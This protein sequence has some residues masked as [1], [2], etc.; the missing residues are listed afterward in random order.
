[1]RLAI[2]SFL[3]AMALPATAHAVAPD[4][5]DGAWRVDAD[6]LRVTAAGIAIPQSAGNLSL[7]KSGEISDQGAGLDNYA[8]FASADGVVQATAYIYMP[9][10]A[11]AAISS[12]MT[13]KAIH[14]RFGPDTRRT[15]FD[16]TS[17]GQHSNTAIR[18]V[19]S[20]ADGQLVTEAAF[21][22]AGRW[23]IKLRVTGP[24]ERM[25]DVN[26]GMNSLLAGLRFEG[27]AS[28]RPAM[29]RQIASCPMADGPGAHVVADRSSGAAGMTD[30][31]FPRDGEDNV[32]VR[33]TVQVGDASYDMLQ[34]VGS[35]DASPVLIPL[36]DA[37]KIMR[38]DRLPAGGGYRLSVHQVGRT[39]VYSAYDRLPT[40]KQIA[41][42]IDGSDRKGATML[43]SAAHAADG[44]VTVSKQAN[45]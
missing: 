5:D 4:A 14:E 21:I 32:C 42:I 8:Q 40:T 16:V 20:G 41:A 9:S 30:L 27:D 19:Y 2:L 35:G 15:A 17:A 33:G 7:I 1:M 34:A 39:D 13:D 6:S 18:S 22:H 31:P 3:L 10:Y 26:S 44:R 36:D 37:G 12:Y 11:D 24:T 28:P 45:R 43:L 38:F 25:Q 23:M 29:A